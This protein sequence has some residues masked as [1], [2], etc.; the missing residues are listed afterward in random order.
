MTQT[1]L[2]TGAAR[3]IGRLIAAHYAKNG[4]QVAAHYHA[5]ENDA[6]S[7]H[8][9]FPQGI[10]L[11]RQDLAAENGGK[12][13]LEKVKEK[14]GP[15]DVLIN[16][17]AVFEN[18]MGQPS[19]AVFTRTMA[20]NLFAPLQMISHLE[21]QGTAPVTTVTMLDATLHLS[22]KD[23]PSYVL[24]KSALQGWLE[25]TA[26]APHLQ[27]YGLLLGPV[28]RNPR[29]SNETFESNVKQMPRGRVTETAAIIAA[30]DRLITSGSA[31]R[32]HDLT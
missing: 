3:R 14:L 23:F 9:E 28:M 5:S 13:L 29:E 2:I 30:L 20:T 12:I 17:A 22:W 7:L 24:S 18:E 4:W 26:F 8:A 10:F 16:N 11:F 15:I 31:Q 27:V 1:I 32:L 6:Q 21:T 19:H 25:R